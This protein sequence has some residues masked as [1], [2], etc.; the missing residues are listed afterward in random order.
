MD[1][2]K[3]L[4]EAVPLTRAELAEICHVSEMAIYLWEEGQ[5]SPRPA[6]I[7]KLADALHVTTRMVMDAVRASQNESNKERAA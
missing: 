7:R 2:L 4:R 3:T 5:R 6:N 1:T